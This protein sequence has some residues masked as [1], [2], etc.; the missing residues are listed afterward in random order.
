MPPCIGKGITP[1]NLGDYVV[2]SMGP[3]SCEVKDQNPGMDLLSDYDWEK[4]ATALA[5]LFGNET[6]NEAL[7]QTDEFLQ[8][9]VTPPANIGPSKDAKPKKKGKAEGDAGRTKR[10]ETQPSKSQP[11]KSQPPRPGPNDSGQAKPAVGALYAEASDGEPLVK[12]GPT[13]SASRRPDRGGGSIPAWRVLRNLTIAS[14]AMVATLL[15]VGFLF[16]RP[17]ST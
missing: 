16:L 7:L 13:Q 3:C 11:S 1:E 10:T 12:G 5:E 6:G 4:S 15:V 14:T 2:F 8:L 9:L 17:R